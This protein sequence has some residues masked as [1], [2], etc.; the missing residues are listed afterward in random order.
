VYG[1]S[2]RAPERRLR[3][4]VAGATE[5][6][7]LREAR[8][9]LTFAD[10]KPPS[11]HSHGWKLSAHWV[12][13]SKRRA[14][15]HVRKDASLLVEEADTAGKVMVELWTGEPGSSDGIALLMEPDGPAAIAPVPLCAC[16]DRGCGNTGIQFSGEIDAKDLGQLVQGLAALPWRHVDPTRLPHWRAG[17]PLP[18]APSE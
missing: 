2:L 3:V 18:F 10:G 11:I 5:N 16:G 1:S 6:Q 14:L 8:G 12:E 17:D 7:P 15:L 4:T 9:V 13:G